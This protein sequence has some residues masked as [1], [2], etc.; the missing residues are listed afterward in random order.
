M[1]FLENSKFDFKKLMNNNSFLIVLSLICAVLIWYGVVSQEKDAITTVRNVPVTI[2][3]ENS[4]LSSLKLQ[5]VGN[6]EYFVDVEIEG[7]RSVV[8]AVGTEDIRVLAK[9]AN[10]TAPGEY[11]LALE[12][13][14]NR[15]QGIII[16]ETIPKT[17]T[18][19]F[20]HFVE[21]KFPIQKNLDTLE[22]AEGYILN[23]DYVSPSEI[24][25]KGPATEMDQIS[26]VNVYREFTSPLSQT[27]S[28]E[29]PILLE[30]NEGEE[31]MPDNLEMS[32]A[33]ATVTLPVLKK[34]I[35]PVTVD[36]IGTP[37]GFDTDKLVFDVSPSEIELAGPVST[38]NNLSELHLGYIDIR[39]LEP[40]LNLTYAA[41]LPPGYIS[42]EN[43]QNIDVKFRGDGIEEKILNVTDIRITNQPADYTIAVQ[44]KTFYGI[45]VFGPK[46]QLDKVSA[47]N[48]VAEINMAEIDLKAGTTT[49]PVS[50][51]IPDCDG[52][53]VFGNDY[54]AVI[55]VREK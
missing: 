9:I 4:A 26:K 21:R 15:N 51:V 18:V 36:F 48:V 25:I 44:T 14:D 16:K 27:S 29:L 20:D 39:T 41:Q 47:K 5:P 53:W 3:V 55:T 40:Q 7:F 17:I 13:Y 30:N 19:R 35:V 12:G 31:I 43:I 34:K 45:K 10:I 1:I 50:F 46:N 37:Q 28:F 49:V 8:G 33:V 2:D 54:S 52:C 6:I 23:Q 38:I 42:V 32:N 11:E 24:T 22:I